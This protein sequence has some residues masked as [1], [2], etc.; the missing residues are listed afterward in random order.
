MRYALCD[1]KEVT[2]MY[3]EGM[4]AFIAFEDLAEKRRV[5]IKAGTVTTPPQVEYADAGE[6][7]IGVTEYAVE[8]GDHVTIKLMNNPGTFEIECTVSSAIARGTLLY[9][10]ADGKVSDASSGSSIGQAMQ[11]GATGQQI[12]VA[13]TNVKS[14]TAATV[15]V[16]DA[17]SNMTGTTVEAVLDEHAKALKTAQYAIFPNAIC[18]ED[19]TA[20]PKFADGSADGWAQ[21]SNKTLALRWNNS[22]TPGKLIASFVMP[23]DLD[24]AAAVVLHL[25]GA[26]VKAGGAEADSPVI[27]VEAYFETA[28]AAPGADTDCGGDSG[29]FL[30]A[31]AANW[32]EKTLS[33]AH[34]DVPAAPCVLTVVFNPK[35][36]Q[37]PADD[38]IMLPPWLE[39]TRKAL[40][41]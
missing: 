11:V 5:K 23:Q 4:K 41:S 33:I 32:Q 15:S 7:A 13:V 19:G 36:G 22:A 8:A 10:A 20:V 21:L 9:G 29:E 1:K 16:T 27:S 26:I 39:V 31:A 14:T 2:L 17:N 30:T 38:F 25:M 3:N 6:D 34:G 18:L 12:E 24:D 35:D 37:L 40:T 28:G